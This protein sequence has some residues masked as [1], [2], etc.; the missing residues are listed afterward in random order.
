M[1]LNRYMYQAIKDWVDAHSNWSKNDAEIAGDMNDLSIPNP[2]P[3]PQVQR[4]TDIDRM[5]DE[6]PTA[7]AKL[8]VLRNFLTAIR[9]NDH[10]LL[11]STLTTMVTG[12]FL[13]VAQATAVY[14]WVQAYEDDPNH[15]PYVSAIDQ[16]SGSNT[17]EAGDI[18]SV[19][20]YFGV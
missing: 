4:T 9:D 17:I 16:V 1:P 13:T 19:R 15:P 2:E 18:Q 20:Q 11:Q 3:A 14:D 12:G 5:V 8:T 6:I 7:T 10:D